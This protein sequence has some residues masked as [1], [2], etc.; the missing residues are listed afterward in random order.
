LESAV[1]LQPG[2]AVP[3]FTADVYAGSPLTLSSLRGKPVWLAFFRYSGCPLCNLQV[4][5][6][7]TRYAELTATGLQIVAVFQAPL[8]EIARNVGKQNAPFPIVSDPEEKLYALYDLEASLSGYISPAN[9]PIM[10]DAVKAGFLM[11]TMHGTKTRLP[12]DFLID[13]QGQL[14]ETFY[15]PIIGA[16]IPFE[17]V[18]QFLT[19]SGQ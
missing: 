16:H 18:E 12:A 5:Q 13:A 3:D 17:R 10:V 8:D 2:S 11:G 1:R 7:I 9:A 19:R 4:Q 15:A 6:M 14:V